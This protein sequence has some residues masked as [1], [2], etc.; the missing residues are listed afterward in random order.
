M[1]DDSTITNLQ[2]DI[3][4]IKQELGLTPQGVYADVRVRLDILETR[5]GTD[6][7]TNVENPFFIGSDGVSIS[8]GVGVPIENR[9]NGSLF[10]RKDGD[11]AD[12][13]YTRQGNSWFPVGSAGAAT[14]QATAGGSISAGQALRTTTDGNVIVAITNL[15]SL[16]FDCVSK[17]VATGGS[18]FDIQIAGPLDPGIANL[19]VGVACAVGVDTSGNLVRATDP[20]CVSAPNWV[21]SCDVYGN[22]TIAPANRGHFDPIDFGAVPDWNGTTGTDNLAAFTACLLATATVWPTTPQ[23][24]EVHVSSGF[25]FFSATLDIANRVFMRGAGMG[26]ENKG[27]GTMLVFP[28]NT[29]GI[30]LHS[31]LDDAAKDSSHSKIQDLTLL[32]DS[33]GTSGH[34]IHTSAVT[35]FVNVG[36]FSFGGD[37]FFVDANGVGSGNAST[38]S[39]VNCRAGTSGGHGFHFFGTDANACSVI[40]GESVVNKKWG[41]FD[42]STGGN[43]F[44]GVHCEGNEGRISGVTG[45][46]TI[47]TKI[48]TVN[49]AKELHIGQGIQ[50][51]GVTGTKKI[52]SITGAPPFVTGAQTV[53]IDTNADAT[54]VD[55]AIIAGLPVDGR[56]HDVKT[57]YEGYAPST[58]WGCYSEAAKNHVTNPA[59]VFGG[60]L[61]QSDQDSGAF[62]N[63]NAGLAKYAPLRIRNELG[64]PQ[65]EATFG[66][67]ASAGRIFTIQ[68]DGGD[69]WTW[70]YDQ[71]I[72]GGWFW[73]RNGSGLWS[74]LFPD[75]ATFDE[76]VLFRPGIGYYTPS[77]S[78]KFTRHITGTVAPTSGTYQER[79]IVWNVNA[80]DGFAGWICTASG[81]PGTWKR[82][83]LIDAYADEAI[84]GAQDDVT[85]KVVRFTTLDGGAGQTQNITLLAVPVD[86]VLD[87]LIVA[88]GVNTA[89][90][91][92]LH[93]HRAQWQ[94]HNSGALTSIGTNDDVDKIAH[95][96][97][98]VTT[99]ASSNDLKLDVV[100]T[101]G[102]EMKWT[103]TIT[104]QRAVETS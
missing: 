98:S 42:E 82:F 85:S 102:E 49:E 36:V 54:V 9:L 2:N 89:G 47:N 60:L 39:F 80:G 37:C 103:I 3:D 29:T 48:L 31:S 95:G 50:I 46:I 18:L 26:D 73:H 101:G 94:R 78:T 58:F 81:T 53:T 96:S 17:A 10:L 90:D 23:R 70:E 25:Y 64:S 1:V 12:G 87:V 43:T 61:A 63:L 91:V 104:I 79:D 92:F 65:I 56:N 4:D 55:A 72:F 30:R 21:G 22:I 51:A 100:G 8:T 84:F 35:Y 59:M 14:F 11:A 67:R 20:L 44:V 38:S 88:L 24:P 6:Q 97:N 74:M 45:S 52:V 76:M 71:S 40:G 69:Y 5:I 86:T 66:D 34:G 57:G 75:V 77:T 93:D 19:G 28:T 62:F 33:I 27:P 99:S 16:P 7:P 83:G 41:I 68:A 15:R 32:C 13:V